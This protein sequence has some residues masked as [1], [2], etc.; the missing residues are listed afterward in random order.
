M[1]KSIFKREIQSCF[2]SFNISDGQQINLLKALFENPIDVTQQYLLKKEIN[3]VD[4]IKSNIKAVIDNDGFIGDVLSLFVIADDLELPDSLREQLARKEP[5]AVFVGAGV[6]KLLGIPLWAELANHGIDHLYKSGHITF[7]EAERIKSENISPKQKLSIFHDI[8][9]PEHSKDFY[10][11][12][13]TPGIG[14]D[15]NP[16]DLLVKLN[17]P[18]VTPNLDHEYWNALGRTHK[19]LEKD[20]PTHVS[21]GFQESTPIITNAI[22][23]IHGSYQSAESYSI[24][25]MSNYL[26]HYSGDADLSKFLRKIF[27]E[28]IVIF[29][30]YGME[31]FEVLR[32]LIVKTKEHHVLVS[33]YLGDANLLRIRKEYFRKA[34]GINAHGY[35]LDVNGY[36]RLYDVIDSWVKKIN[37]ELQAG[38]YPKTEEFSDVKL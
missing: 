7:V 14:I 37:F 9:P 10:K 38:F 19:D 22:Y 32:E 16:Y 35:Y 8:L 27:N 4:A 20:K 23:Q 36:D 12:H 34:F 2:Q 1:R 13:F 25:T 30:G 17:M 29:I 3:S 31:E 28:Y 26:K 33:A 15:R 24:I 11:R 18:K 5:I 6:S 21:L